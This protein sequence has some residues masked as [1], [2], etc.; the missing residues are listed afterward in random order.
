MIFWLT[1]EIALQIYVKTYHNERQKMESNVHM[2]LVGC[3]VDK[4][5][6]NPYNIDRAEILVDSPESNAE[7]RPSKLIKHVPDVFV[8]SN[9]DRPAIVG[10][11]KTPNDI[12]KRHTFAQF[13]EFLEWCN[14]HKGSTLVIA[15]PWQAE[16][17][18]ADVIRYLQK[19]TNTSGVFV[20]VLKQLPG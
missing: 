9:K 13:S 4:L 1:Y 18:A 12:E 15:V 11:A 19:R 3:L 16:R 20:D 10:E 5:L 6:G 7:T 14:L 17:L 2:T 8:P